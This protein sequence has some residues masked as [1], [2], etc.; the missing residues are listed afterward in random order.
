MRANDRP[1]GRDAAPSGDGKHRPASAQ[2]SVAVLLHEPTFQALLEGAPDAIVIVDAAGSIVI[3]NKQTEQLFG[4]DRSE[5]LGTSVEL[6]L[7]TR[8]HAQHRQHRTAFVADPHTRPMGVG[9]ELLARRNDGSEFAVEISLSPLHTAA[10]LLV[11]AVIRDVTERK[12]ALDELQSRVRQ[13]AVV[14]TLGQRA[15]ATSDVDG[16]LSEVTS[17]VLAA[18]GVAH[19]GIF[20]LLADR[21]A[22]RLRAGSGW[23]AGAVGQTIVPAGTDSFAGYTLLANAPVIVNDFRTET[24]FRTPQLLVEHAAISGVSAIIEGQ[25]RPFGVL[26]VVTTQ[27]RTF[28]THDV[29]FLQAVAH[30]VAS[31]IERARAAAELERQIGL[32]TT[33]LNTLVSFSRQLLRV[34]SIDEVVREALSQ[35]LGAGA[36]RA[37]GSDLFV[38]INPTDDLGCAPAPASAR[39]PQ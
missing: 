14:A 36:G 20:E 15:L 29:D 6:L 31:A 9:L 17:L 39:C 28:T 11:T 12:Q 4:Y 32:R 1:S 19:C 26:Y 27:P 37:A 5:L 25:E 24:R 13:Q 10:D 16:L 35:A 21:T 22:L 7:P 8:L 18:L 38:R 2:P 23:N 30:V 33:H 3:V 34:R